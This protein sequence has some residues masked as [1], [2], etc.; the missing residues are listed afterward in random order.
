MVQDQTFNAVGFLGVYGAAT[1]F[2]YNSGY[3]IEDLCDCNIQVN[4]PALLEGGGVNWSR[5][6]EPLEGR[7]YFIEGKN[8]NGLQ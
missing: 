6:F 5:A 3:M 1:S 7:D 8:Y 4:W 2:G